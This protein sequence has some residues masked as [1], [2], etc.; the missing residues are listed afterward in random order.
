MANTI[1][2]TIQTVG[3]SSRQVIQYYTLSSD[4]T[5]ET[6]SNVYSVSAAATAGLKT[7]STTS[8]ILNIKG[9]CSIAAGSATASVTLFFKAST[10]VIALNLP[11]NFPFDF[12]FDRLGGLMNYS[13][14]GQTG[15]IVIT[16]TGLASGDKIAFI[17]SVR[18]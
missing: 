7:T 5:N 3:P 4:G 16:T 17:I 13:G 11:I 14:S 8:S 15:D 10:N 9:V 12:D 2:N 1:H 6:A 18:P